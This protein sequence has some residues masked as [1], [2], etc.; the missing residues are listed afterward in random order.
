M[1]PLHGTPRQCSVPGAGTAGISDPMQPGDNDFAEAISEVNADDQVSEEYAAE[2]THGSSSGPGAVGSATVQAAGLQTFVNEAPFIGTALEQVV[3][4]TVSDLVA[5]RELGC[6]HRECI[7][8][9][10]S[11]RPPVGHW[12]AGELDLAFA[13]ISN[14]VDESFNVGAEQEHGPLT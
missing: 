2:C 11:V 14:A 5:M 12:T 3:Q 1:P 9:C 4:L 13:I 6:S 7:K 8:F 10:K